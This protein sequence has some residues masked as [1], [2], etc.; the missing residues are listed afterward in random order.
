MNENDLDTFSA[1]LK[2]LIKQENKKKNM[3]KQK[4]G[5]ANNEFN[6]INLKKRFNF[7]NIESR[8]RNKNGSII[9]KRS[10]I[11]KDLDFI[12]DKQILYLGKKQKKLFTYQLNK[13]LKFL[14]KMYTMDYSLIVG[15]HYYHKYSENDELNKKEVTLSKK[16]WFTYAH[17]GIRSTKVLNKNEDNTYAIYYIG[18]VLMISFLH[19]HK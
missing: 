7:N 1:Q 3:N 12:D 9:F 15:I 11:L 19:E 13:D 18:Y 17:G 5:Y 14:T 4:N 6:E 16:E 10:Q 8:D 2:D